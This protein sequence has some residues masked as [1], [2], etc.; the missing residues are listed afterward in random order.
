MESV[1][2]KILLNLPLTDVLYVVITSF[3]WLS[4]LL[5]IRKLIEILYSPKEVIDA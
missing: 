5:L 3:L 4:A 1:N 2:S